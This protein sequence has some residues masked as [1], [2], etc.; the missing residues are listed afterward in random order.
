MISSNSGT[1][2]MYA[3]IF[4]FISAIAVYQT[5][6]QEAPTLRVYNIYI[7]LCILFGRTTRGITNL[8]TTKKKLCASFFGRVGGTS[9]RSLAWRPT[10]FAKFT[11]HNTIRRIDARTWNRRMS[12]GWV[13]RLPY[14]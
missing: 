11:L 13:K 9:A 10:Y 14:I 3:H 6:W 5:S 8:A 1:L 2:C 12:N 7:K 4:L